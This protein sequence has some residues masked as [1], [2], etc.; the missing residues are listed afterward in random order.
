MLGFKHEQLKAPGHLEYGKDR[1][2]VDTGALHTDSDD[3]V[4]PAA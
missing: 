3:A 2:P 1:H 4:N